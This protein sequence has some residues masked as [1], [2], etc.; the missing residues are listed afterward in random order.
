MT[1]SGLSFLIADDHPIVL[2]GMIK[3]IKDEYPD[4]LIMEAANG[5]EVLEKVRK[6]FFNLLIL[7]ISMPGKN[8]IEILKQLKSEDYKMPV[9]F[10]SM[11]PEDQYAV[12]AIKA[13]AYG[14]LPKSSAPEELTHAIKTIL[15]GKKFI[16]FSLAENLATA[17]EKKFSEQLHETLSDRE[18]DVL[19]LIASGKTVSQV[20]D[21]LSLSATTVS[22]YRARI[23]EKMNMKTNAELTNYAIKN[24]LVDL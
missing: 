21:E 6:V 23:L 5:N 19:K 15:A 8:G 14:Y 18:F 24:G 22:T 9:L 11:Y 3:L 13:G 17:I 7:D 20:A 1:N 12:R 2:K 10:L 16:P 4:A